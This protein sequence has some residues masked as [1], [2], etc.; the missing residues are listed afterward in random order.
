MC[1]QSVPG[2]I[3]LNKTSFIILDYDYILTLCTSLL[4]EVFLNFRIRSGMVI[5]IT[6]L[7][8]VIRIRGFDGGDEE[9]FLSVGSRGGVTSSKKLGKL[10]TTPE[11]LEY[12]HIRA[13]SYIYGVQHF[14][15]YSVMS[16]T[17]LQGH[18]SL[19]LM[20]LSVLM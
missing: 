15:R 20:R 14:S 16:V 10:W 13:A 9:S 2:N 12:T 11:V 6:F 5:V 19:S 3:F 1:S 18:S 4:I 7:L 17:I 8:S